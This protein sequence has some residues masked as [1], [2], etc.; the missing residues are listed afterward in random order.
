[1]TKFALKLITLIIV[2]SLVLA[3]I[4]HG[5]ITKVNCCPPHIKMLHNVTKQPYLQAVKTPVS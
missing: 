4:K 2:G 1:M 5:Q 3:S